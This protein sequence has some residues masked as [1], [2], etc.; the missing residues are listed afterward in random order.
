MSTERKD[1]EAPALVDYG[2]VD[3][4]TKGTLAVN[5]ADFP[6]G[7]QL[8]TPVPGGSGSAPVRG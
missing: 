7:R 6:L 3:E 1:Y 8:V 4:V 5:T 2:T